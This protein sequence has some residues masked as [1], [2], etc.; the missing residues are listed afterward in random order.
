VL[1]DSS[2]FSSSPIFLDAVV[3]LLSSI[4]I[5]PGIPGFPNALAPTSPQPHPA[6]KLEKYCLTPACFL[7][8]N[9]MQRQY[10]G[11]YYAIRKTCWSWEER[12][13]GISLK[14]HEV[15][16][17]RDATFE[18]MCGLYVRAHCSTHAHTQGKI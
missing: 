12:R 8:S 2:P 14:I 18:M 10:Q 9:E 17:G 13:G 6:L 11:W 16:P 1:I 5:A 4:Y 7:K 15:S 3:A